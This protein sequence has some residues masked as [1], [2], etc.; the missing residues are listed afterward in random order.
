PRVGPQDIEA[1]QLMLLED[2]HCLTD[3]ALEVCGVARSA[4]GIN[5]GA[6]SLA[7]LSHLVAAGF[8]L[9]MMPELAVGAEC[10]AAKGLSVQRFSEPQPLRHIGLVRR[11]STSGEGWFQDLATVARHTG[12]GILAEAQKDYGPA[13]G[14]PEP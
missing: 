7:T 4:A 13:I 11:A 12:H 2:G 10:S 1:E 3:Q 9:T 6:G 14:A 5:M 8:G